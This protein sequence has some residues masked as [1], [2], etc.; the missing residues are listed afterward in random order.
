MLRQLL[1]SAKK[2]EKALVF[3]VARLQAER[4]Q[5]HARHKENAGGN[6]CR[7]AAQDASHEQERQRMELKDEFC[8]ERL[9]R[10]KDELQRQLDAAQLQLKTLQEKLNEREQEHDSDV[11]RRLTEAA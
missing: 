11:Q 7:G 1:E 2:R 9:Y 4:E 6:A 10:E 8:R 5:M 3:E